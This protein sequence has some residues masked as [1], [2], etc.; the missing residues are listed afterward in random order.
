MKC[1][2]FSRDVVRPCMSPILVIG[3]ITNI[4]MKKKIIRAELRRQAPGFTQFFFVLV[5]CSDENNNMKY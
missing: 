1:H 4:F 3:I 2:A 5:F